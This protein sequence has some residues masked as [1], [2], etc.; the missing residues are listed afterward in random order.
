MLT[1][2]E[3]TRMEPAERRELIARLTRPLKDVVRETGTLQHQRRLRLGVA[4]A[5]VPSTRPSAWNRPPRGSVSPSRS[6][7][8]P[9]RN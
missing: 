2:E 4:A 5:A 7:S 1:D 8:A 6:E 3:I 9:T